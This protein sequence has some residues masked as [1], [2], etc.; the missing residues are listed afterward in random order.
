MPLDKE[1]QV[2]ELENSMIRSK[3]EAIVFDEKQKD[4]IEEIKQRGN[5]NIKQYISMT[6]MD[7]YIDLENLLLK[8]KEL[9]EKGEK[10]FVQKEVDS[11]KM[12]TLLFTSRNNFHVK[13][14]YAKS[15]W[16]SNKYL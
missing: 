6:P 12:S 7:G 11:Y 4:K 10:S 2:D 14:S 1:L 15:K 16:N 8:G 5:T 3:I 9:I 13:G